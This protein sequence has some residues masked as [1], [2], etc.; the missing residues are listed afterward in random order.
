MRLREIRKASGKLGGNPILVGNLDKQKVNQNSNQKPTPSSSTSSS[1]S[2]STSDKEKNKKE[3]EVFEQARKL[4][5]GSKRGHKTE[6]ENLKKKHKDWKEVI[7]LFKSAIEAEIQ[8]RLDANGEFRP[9]W[10]NFK[11][12]I[13]N[14][15]W[16]LELPG[17]ARRKTAGEILRGLECEM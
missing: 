17:P 13:N 1:T 8:W 15:S 6:F 16:E 7:P 14:R 2:T 9:G 3:K 10:Q 4:Y 12:W 5:K 11:T